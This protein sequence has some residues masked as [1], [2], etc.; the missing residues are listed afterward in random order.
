M[1]KILAIVVALMMVMALSVS[2]FAEEVVYAL[3][4]NDTLGQHLETV[5]IGNGGVLPADDPDGVGSRIA[6]NWVNGSTFN[7]I[8]DAMKTEGAVLRIT[9][10]GTL[11]AI[12]F[13]SSFGTESFV[14]ITDVTEVDGKN[15]AIVPCADILAAAPDVVKGGYDWC[16]LIVTQDGEV[17][18]AGFEVVTGYETAAAE[19]E[20]EA[21]APAAEAEAEAPAAEAEAP[22]AEAEAPAAE[23]EAP[24]AEETKAPATG[25][26][27]AV[28]RLCRAF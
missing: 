4:A 16:N 20:A 1:K 14:D 12:G 23:A 21:E 11:K 25:L 5:T 6:T 22:A 19:T 15:V 2:V 26:V 8:L 7:A 24:A 3:G 17:A 9:Y 18:L 10:T 28:V 13:Q 27:L